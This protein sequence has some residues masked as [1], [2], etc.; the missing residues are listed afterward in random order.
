MMLATKHDRRFR[1]LGHES[2]AIQ[3]RVELVERPFTERGYLLSC[4]VADGR[5]TLSTGRA[6]CFCPPYHPAYTPIQR[7]E[8]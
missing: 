8:Q 4:L 7:G 6:L 1:V 2:S 5:K 3:H